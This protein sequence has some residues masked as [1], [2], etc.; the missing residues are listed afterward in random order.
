MAIGQLT[1]LGKASPTVSF[2]VNNQ[3]R[4]YQLQ[5]QDLVDYLNTVIEAGG[6]QD[7]EDRLANNANP[8]LGAGMIGYVGRTV[9]AKL[10]DIPSLEDYGASVVDGFT[11]NQDRL[12][13]AAAANQGKAVWVPAKTFVS[14]DNIPGF[15][16]VFWLGPGSVKRG[17]D[18][19]YV[20]PKDSQTN[21][22]YIAASGGSLTN[23]GLSS[24]QPF[25]TFQSCFDATKN[26]GPV[27]SG[28]W[29]LIAAAGTY[30]FSGGAQTFST[31]SKNRV[32][33][34][35]PA[36]GGHPNVPTCLIDGGGIQPQYSHGLNID[37]PGVRVQVQDIKAQN[38]TEASGFTRVGFLFANDVDAY[39]Q[40]LH[41]FACSWT[42]VMAKECSQYRGNG[43]IYDANSVGAYGFI[44]DSTRSSFGYGNT[45][46]ANGPV[47]KKALSSGVYWSTGSQGHCDWVNFE[48]N[49]VA[50]LCAE[51]SRCDTVGNNYKRNTVA[52]RALTGGF[53]A[54]GGAAEVFNDGTA[55]ANVTN[56]EYKA[57]SGDI[58]ELSVQGSGSWQRVAF[59][60]TNRALSGTTPTV[61]TTPYTIKANRLKGVGK[62]C[63]VLS[64]GVF[65]QA[66]AGSTLTVNFGGM[67][68]TVTVP[69]AATNAAFELDVTLYE[70]QGGYRAI[71]KLSQGLSATRFGTATAG[72]VNTSDQDISVAA[73]LANAGDSMNIYRTDV[74][75][76]G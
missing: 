24:G 65:T 12:V 54:S 15:H 42:G 16:S 37:G 72:F 67:A 14:T 48:D 26:Y 74:F 5:M 36:V 25:S 61:L 20:N 49:A 21:R 57:Y 43:G 38:F 8:A 19:F 69:A 10:Q 11:S 70:V 52:K 46:T 2:A 76:M 31:P 4:D 29:Q 41:T 60:R 1:Y 68:F 44:S 73:T 53:F 66:T 45:S 40:N 64:V 33:I 32:V 58:S 71:G 27:L 13:A 23:D 9:Y 28:N 47:V 56:V 30:D 55:D 17:T 75:L 18:I 6:T 34:R 62:S 22:L 3:D 7:L 59:D 63:R 39:H 35:G 50:F 51:N